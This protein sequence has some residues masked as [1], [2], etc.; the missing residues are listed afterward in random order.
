MLHTGSKTTVSGEYD[1]PATR[2]APPTIPANK[3]SIIEPYKLGVTNTSNCERKI[4]EKK[5]Y[6]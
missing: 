4:L 5:N 3:L 6:I 1:A 2:P